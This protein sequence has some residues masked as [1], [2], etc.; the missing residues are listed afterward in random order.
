[1]AASIRIYIYIEAIDFFIRDPNLLDLRK[2]PLKT[3][4]GWL[5]ILEQRG[6]YVVETILSYQIKCPRKR[7]WKLLEAFLKLYVYVKYYDKDV[8]VWHY[9]IHTYMYAYGLYIYRIHTAI[10]MYLYVCIHTPAHILASPDSNSWELWKT[11]NFLLQRH[12]AA[13]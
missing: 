6:S 1:M 9:N 12:N 5:N 2:K 4:R 7:Y 11:E 13:R 3:I 10:F 8:Y